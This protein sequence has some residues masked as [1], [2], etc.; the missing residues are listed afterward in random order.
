VTSTQWREFVDRVGEASAAA[1]WVTVSGSLPPGVGADGYAQLVR[2]ENFAVDTTQ[3]GTAKPEFMKV[4]AAE[5]AELTG[6]TVDTDG[7]ALAAARTLR[8][9]LG[10][11]GKAAVV[12]RGANGALV[13]EPDGGEL[14][15]R[16]DSWG[17][18]PVG[19]GD[20]FFAGLAV[21]LERNASWPEAL[22]AALGAGAANAEV[23]GAGR[24]DRQR[25]ELLAARAEAERVGG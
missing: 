20:A 11:D 4:N 16:L 15:G 10:G 25:A 5:A 18:Y 13:V 7:D 1:T 8:E 22:K 3:L 24:L 6:R 17:A 23:P 12:T 14:R 19:S 21:S 2:G 9:R